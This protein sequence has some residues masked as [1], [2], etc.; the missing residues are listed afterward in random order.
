MLRVI[1][2]HRKTI[3]Y[4][5]EIF[6]IVLLLTLMIKQRIEF[7]MYYLPECTLEHDN[8]ST[9]KPGLYGNCHWLNK[10]QIQTIP[11]PN[12]FPGETL[13]PR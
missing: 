8:G 10:N 2:K 3:M 12:P 1:Q 4:L 7:G 11:Q 9:T 13:K 6:L 5:V